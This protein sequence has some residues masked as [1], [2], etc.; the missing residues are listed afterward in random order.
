VAQDMNA[1]RAAAIY[2]P[3]AEFRVFSGVRAPPSRPVPSV[4]PPSPLLSPKKTQQQKRQ[5]PHA[6]PFVLPASPREGQA[7]GLRKQ[8]GFPP[9]A[10]QQ[11]QQQSQDR[12][13]RRPHLAKQN[14]VMWVFCWASDK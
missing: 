5:D 13:P 14:C 2:D 4:S 9:P 6:L 12:G 10:P 3:H 7:D 11:P 8:R 1:P